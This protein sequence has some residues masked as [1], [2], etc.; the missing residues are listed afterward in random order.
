MKKF[1]EQSRASAGKLFCKVCREELSLKSSSHLNHLK[2]QKHQDGNRRLQRKE[3]GRQDIAKELAVHNEET[4]MVGGTLTENTQVFC[5][6]VVST[7]MRA[8]VP[9]N[10]LD[11]FRELFEE[12][13]YRLT[14][15]RNLFD[16]IPFIQ[17]HEVSAISE[18]INGKDLS[19]CFDGTTRLGEALAIV[20]CYI[21]DGSKVG[22]STDGGKEFDW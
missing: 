14:G 5:V 18:E 15:K 16:L 20:V 3:A 11:V 10:K 2:Y 8:G 6:K 4:R 13:R 17:K 21:D 1:P 22:S 7:F 19:V 9:L 12:N